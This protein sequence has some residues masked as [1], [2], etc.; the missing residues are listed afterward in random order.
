MADLWAAILY[1]G[2]GAMLSHVT[3]AHWR[4]LLDYSANAIEVS[5][6]RAGVASIEGQVRVYTRRKRQRMLCAGLPTTTIPDTLIDLAAV[7]DLK[8][9]RRALA[10]LDY[11]EQIHQRDLDLAALTAVCAKGRK[12]SKRLRCALARHQPE[13]AFTNGKL[14]ECLLGLCER[15]KLPIPRFRVRLHGILSDAYWA[16]QRL[17]IEVDGLGNHSSPAQRRRDHANDLT[18]RSFGLTVLRYDWPQL[19][20]QATLRLIRREVESHMGEPVR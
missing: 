7:A 2:P 6:P 16:E 3:A 18:L 4:G 11:N 15:W 20:D 9:V 14:E 17:V 13:L 12:G 8:V 1:A 5:T 10:K 19:H